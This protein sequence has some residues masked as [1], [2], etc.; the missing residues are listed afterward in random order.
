MHGTTVAGKKWSFTWLSVCRQRNF[1]LKGRPIHNTYPFY[2]RT[3]TTTTQGAQIAPRLWL[4]AKC[5][6]WRINPFY[7]RTTTQGAQ[8]ALK[9]WLHSADV[10]SS[11]AN[12]CLHAV[13]TA[14][15]P[16]RTIALPERLRQH[17]ATSHHLAETVII[18]KTGNWQFEHANWFNASKHSSHSHTGR[19]ATTG[20]ST[21]YCPCIH[22]PYQLTMFRDSL[23]LR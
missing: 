18:L 11:D 23:R 13:L 16:I 6:Q 19:Y 21:V 5:S 2:P 17:L 20:R 1:V 14:I 9:L 4:H 8:I 15:N 10:Q 3:T 22:F 12:R 7:P